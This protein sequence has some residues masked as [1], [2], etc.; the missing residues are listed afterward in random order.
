MKVPE[1]K[2]VASNVVAR[3]VSKRMI[4]PDRVGKI[5]DGID[6]C[7]ANYLRQGDFTIV[8]LT[9][10]TSGL[11]LGVGVSKRN[12]VDNSNPLRGNALALSRAIQSFALTL[13]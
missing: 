4:S 3:M 2:S 9:G 11:T 13:G 1:F 12:P 5:L 7:D 8:L 6:E 10:K